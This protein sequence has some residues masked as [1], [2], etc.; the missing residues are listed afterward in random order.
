[1]MFSTDR[2][3]E[4]GAECPGCGNGIVST[5]IEDPMM[6]FPVYCYCCGK[7]NDITID[8]FRFYGYGTPRIVLNNASAF[9]IFREIGRS[10]GRWED[11]KLG[12]TESEHLT[13][14]K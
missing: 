12:M 6:P 4:Y 14:G 5:T 9:D 2:A 10:Y 8:T 11:S 13:E 1:M 7:T 3:E